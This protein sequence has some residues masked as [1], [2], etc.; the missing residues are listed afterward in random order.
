MYNKKKE[1][2]KLNS[3]CSEHIFH[4]SSQKDTD[5]SLPH[6]ASGNKKKL[7][8]DI[9]GFQEALVL[10]VKERVKRNSFPQGY[11]KSTSDEQE[12]EW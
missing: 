10:K 2:V 8:C 11:C 4:F 1:L 5:S 6:N 7:K 3:K 9:N 12:W